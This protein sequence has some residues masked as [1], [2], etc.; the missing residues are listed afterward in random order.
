MRIAVVTDDGKTISNHFGM[1]PY[2]HV[3]TIE[4]HKVATYEVRSKAHHGQGEGHMQHHN[5]NH[6][7]MFTP[8][9]DCQILICGGMGEPAYQKAISSGLEVILTGN[10]IS[11]A[12][13]AYLSNTLV[14]DSGRIHRH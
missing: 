11:K 10:E 9:A 8:I 5:H 7:D 2:Y 6:E 4:D 13:A 14:S 1:A 12:L 3:F